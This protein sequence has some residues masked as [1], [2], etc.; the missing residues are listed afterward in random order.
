MNVF[1][2]GGCKNGKSHYAQEL[3]KKMSEESGT[4]LYYVATMISTG[5]ED[6]RRIAN[7]V[8]DRA[9]M[10]FITLEQP[11]NLCNIAARSD[12]EMRGTFLLDSITA[13]LQNEMFKLSGEYCPDAGEKVC[14]DLRRFAGLVGNSVMVSDYIYSDGGNYDEMTE[15]YRRSL[16]MCDRCAADVCEQVIEVVFGIFNRWK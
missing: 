15:N 8:K 12:V 6:D 16:A 2:G 7:H 9:G 11:T 14:A 4:P 3:A 5:R 13:L 10:G 1:I